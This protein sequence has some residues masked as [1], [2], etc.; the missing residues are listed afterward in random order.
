[1]CGP[2]PVTTRHAMRAR[3]SI[4]RSARIASIARPSRRDTVIASNFPRRR[5][6]ERAPAEWLVQLNDSPVQPAG[7]R[8]PGEVGRNQP[9]GDVRDPR[10]LHDERENGEPERDDLK[11]RPIWP[12]Q[13]EEQWA[14]ENVED[15]VD[16]KQHD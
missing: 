6:G 3:P 14:P 1:M 16:R 15:A 7:E 4:A 11:E 12:A 13:P 5:G 8:D 2:P 9:T 10:Q